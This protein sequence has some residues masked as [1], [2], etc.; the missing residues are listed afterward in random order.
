MRADRNSGQ[1]YDDFWDWLRNDGHAIWILSLI[2][3][4]A[5][6]LSTTQEL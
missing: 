2:L 5:A 1:V 3:A 4:Y 6:Y